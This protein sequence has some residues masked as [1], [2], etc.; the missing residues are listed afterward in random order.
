[1]SLWVPCPLWGVICNLWVI[2]VVLNL[3]KCKY[4]SG[5]A[6]VAGNHSVRGLG[7]L[8]GIASTCVR[9]W[10]VLLVPSLPK[11]VPVVCW[12]SLKKDHWDPLLNLGRVAFWASR[13]TQIGSAA[14]CK[15]C[16]E[17]KLGFKLWART[18]MSICIRQMV[19]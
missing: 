7:P 17:F 14:S 5:S 15:H 10:V 8:L 19:L 2:P 4:I 18:L 6:S 13:A 3:P 1:M 12:E 11:L 9:A 16:W